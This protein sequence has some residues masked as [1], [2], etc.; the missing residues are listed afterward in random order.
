MI[1]KLSEGMKEMTN[2]NTLDDETIRMT[3]RI[4]VKRLTTKH[5][6]IWMRQLEMKRREMCEL[7]ELLGFDE[8][9]KEIENQRSIEKWAK[10]CTNHF[11]K[12][13]KRTLFEEID[14][15]VWSESESEIARW[16]KRNKVFDE[17][18]ETE[19][20]EIWKKGGPPESEDIR[21]NGKY[22]WEGPLQFR[23]F[24]IPQVYNSATFS[25]CT[26]PGFWFSIIL[27]FLPPTHSSA[28][29][30][31]HGIHRSS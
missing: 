8:V 11:T 5:V 29:R 13:T 19:I 17:I 16:F 6:N 27:D 4:V 31:F 10:R 28:S 14:N 9:K 30:A 1:K 23:K 21:L 26:I 2:E 3:E 24:T 22:V 20:E 15:M 12:K 25:F 18:T 7:A